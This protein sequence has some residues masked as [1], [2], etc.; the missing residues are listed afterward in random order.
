[1]D[2]LIN[3]GFFGALIC[4]G[5]TFYLL[6][7]KNALWKKFCAGMLFCSF[8]AL[9]GFFAA[10]HLERTLHPAKAEREKAALL[11]YEIQSVNA[12]SEREVRMWRRGIPCS[13]TYN[14]LVEKNDPSEAEFER[15]AE[16]I[17]E[18]DA[19]PRKNWNFIY[20]YIRTPEGLNSG[21]AYMSATYCLNGSTE[22]S[23]RV[24]PGDYNDRFRFVV[25]II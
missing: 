7:I 6:R 22:Q 10:P 15:I 24:K 19:R 18:K 1:M 11:K 23:N 2:P 25:R 13:L 3:A 5:A 8:L 16:D 20:F 4:A 17:I 9:A 21:V 12:P 14:I